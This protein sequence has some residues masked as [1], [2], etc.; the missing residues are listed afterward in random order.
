M[1]TVYECEKNSVVIGLMLKRQCHAILVSFQN[2]NLS[3]HQ[4]N[5]KNNGLVLL[6]KTI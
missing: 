1:N 5:P 4:L 6:V 3:L 2:L